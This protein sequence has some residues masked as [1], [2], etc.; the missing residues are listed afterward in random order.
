MAVMAYTPSPV[1]IKLDPADAPPRPPAID[2]EHADRCGDHLAMLLSRYVRPNKLGR[3]VRR[4]KFACEGVECRADVTFWPNKGSGRPTR[5]PEPLPMLI[6][7]VVGSGTFQPGRARRFQWYAERGVWEL[8]RVD[9]SAQTVETW[10]RHERGRR[11][12]LLSGGRQ[13]TPGGKVYVFSTGQW[14]SV[15]SIFDA[16]ANLAALS[17]P[18]EQGP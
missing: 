4:D 12:T 7:E 6:A 17:A 18:Q 9:P 14:L 13:G 16:A 5:G 11:A 2:R 8:V 3:V 15:E 10:C 1:T